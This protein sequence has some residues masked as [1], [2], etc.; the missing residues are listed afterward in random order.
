MTAEDEK[1]AIAPNTLQA[2]DI[3]SNAVYALNLAHAGS[4]PPVLKMT[5]ANSAAGVDTMPFNG[6][7]RISCMYNSIS[8]WSKT[9]SQ[10]S[11]RSRIGDPLFKSHSTFDRHL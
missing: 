10:D 4:Q 9:D 11:K 2:R 5:N 6:F 1:E 8:L 3:S 7:R